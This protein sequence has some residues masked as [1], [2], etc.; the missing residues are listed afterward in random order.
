MTTEYA[1]I[2]VGT[3][4]KISKGCRA[5]DLPKGVSAKVIEVKELGA[6]FNY[7]VSVKLQFLNGFKAGKTRTLEARH[8]N[9]LKDGC[10]RLSNASL[11]F[12]EIT[13]A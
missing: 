8:P 5:F 6:E 4:V 3:R 9:R 10:V 12:I 7:N 11:Q 1:P 13:R 2:A